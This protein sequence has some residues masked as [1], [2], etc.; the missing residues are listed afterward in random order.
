MKDFLCFFHFVILCCSLRFQFLVRSIFHQIKLI[1]R[2]FLTKAALV[3]LHCNGELSRKV[4]CLTLRSIPVYF[5]D[6]IFSIF[7]FKMFW[8]MWWTNLSRWRTNILIWLWKKWSLSMACFCQSKNAYWY[9]RGTDETCF[10]LHSKL[11]SQLTRGY[12]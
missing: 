3:T 10:R 6:S 7:H 5:S 9:N 1:L 2:L 12:F 4:G 8:R 11:F